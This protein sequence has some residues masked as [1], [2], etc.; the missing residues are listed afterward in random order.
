MAD[1]KGA[2]LVSAIS[3]I[4]ATTKT[5]DAIVGMIRHNNLMKEN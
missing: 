3:F 1:T 5:Q 4:K 2:P